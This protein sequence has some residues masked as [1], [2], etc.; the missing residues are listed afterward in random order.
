MSLLWRVGDTSE[1]CAGSVAH[2]GRA[3]LLLAAVGIAVL[4][5]AVSP[6][7][8][9]SRHLAMPDIDAACETDNPYLVAACYPQSE[10]GVSATPRV[11][12]CTQPHFTSDR[13]RTVLEVQ[14][15]FTL[16]TFELA[17]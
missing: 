5:A 10:S 13:C 11:A 17:R 9:P 2:K 7:T 6:A 3:R 12:L 14:V 8:A 15:P 4:I 16:S 1:G